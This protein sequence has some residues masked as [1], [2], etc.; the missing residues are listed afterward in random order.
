MGKQEEIATLE[1]P[2]QKLKATGTMK[3]WKPE[4]MKCSDMCPNIGK[5]R[6]TIIKR[7]ALEDSNIN[8]AERETTKST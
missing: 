6:D 2:N 7:E 3:N 8:S 5:F 4:Q 1:S